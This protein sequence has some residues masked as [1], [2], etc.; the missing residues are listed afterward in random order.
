MEIIENE[1][2]P[3]EASPAEQI[4]EEKRDPVEIMEEAMGAYQEAQI[5]WNQGDLDAAISALDET[6]ETFENRAMPGRNYQLNININF[7]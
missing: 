7:N 3:P 6:Y 5:A 4:E 2:P 1:P